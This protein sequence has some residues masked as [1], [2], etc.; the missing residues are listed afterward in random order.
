MDEFACL[1]EC[2]WVL[3]PCC[4]VCVSLCWDSVAMCVCLCVGALLLCGYG[5]AVYAILGS[6]DLILLVAN[7]KILKGGMKTGNAVVSFAFRKAWSGGRWVGILGKAVAMDEQR[8]DELE[9]GKP[10]GK[11]EKYLPGEIIRTRTSPLMTWL[12][13]EY[14]L[15]AVSNQG[16]N[17]THRM[18]TS[19]PAVSQP[20]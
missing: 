20:P 13:N 15:M 3:G 7:E 18:R 1:C 11:C 10:L 5:I 2:V 6:S 17:N 12:P 19:R 14:L 9:P 4:C 16:G 8:D